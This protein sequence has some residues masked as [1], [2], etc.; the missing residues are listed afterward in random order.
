M[1]I[2][3]SPMRLATSLQRAQ[4]SIILIS[5]PHLTT[6]TQSP[7]RRTFNKHGRWTMP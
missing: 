2:K 7:R 5:P 4:C 6:R 3:S 1:F